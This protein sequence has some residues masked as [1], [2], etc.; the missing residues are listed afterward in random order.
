LSSLPPS[1]QVR[2][3]LTGKAPPDPMA[4]LW[5][6]ARKRSSVL[7]FQLVGAMRICLL[8]RIY[9]QNAVCAWV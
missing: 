7:L 1:P 5:D 9:Y 8:S 6:E 4:F 2:Q 3:S